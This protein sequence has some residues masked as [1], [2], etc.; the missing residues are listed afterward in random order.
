MYIIL[1]SIIGTV[2]YSCAGGAKR[3]NYN[4][5]PIRSKDN[6]VWN[7]CIDNDT[8]NLCKYECM[9]YKRNKC[10]EGYE[11][12]VKLSISSAVESGYV[13]ISRSYYMYLL[14]KSL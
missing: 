7:R 2:I 1:G 12:T 4:N 13:M 14:K 8:A 11:R 6:T 9:K 3:P 5:F 10:V